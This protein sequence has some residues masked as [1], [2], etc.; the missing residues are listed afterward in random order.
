MSD[1]VSDF[2][3]VPCIAKS[4]AH[5]NGKTSELVLKLVNHWTRMS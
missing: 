5:T 1:I 4:F 3:I 2:R